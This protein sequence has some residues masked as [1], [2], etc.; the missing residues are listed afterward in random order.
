[1]APH[2][3]SP[4]AL[5]RVGLALVTNA[6]WWTNQ[7]LNQRQTNANQRQTNAAVCMQP[8]LKQGLLQLFYVDNKTTYGLLY[9]CVTYAR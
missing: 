4:L 8:T 5:D 2:Y 1:M 7:R 9:H 3:D 6:A